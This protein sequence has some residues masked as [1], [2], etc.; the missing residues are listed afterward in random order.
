VGTVQ[1]GPPREP[2]WRWAI[3]TVRLLAVTTWLMLAVMF[4]FERGFP[5]G[6]RHGPEHPADESAS[7][8][9]AVAFGLLLC[10]IPLGFEIWAAVRGSH[11]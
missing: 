1:K 7:L 3:A 6:H 5:K 11:R 10:T 4:S 2:S 9:M 8:K